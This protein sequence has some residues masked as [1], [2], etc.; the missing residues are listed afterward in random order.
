MGEETGEGRQ[1]MEDRRWET[2]DGTGDGRQETREEGQKM[3]DGRW[4]KMR[5]CFI[6]K[7]MCF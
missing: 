2:R 7:I 6:R 3:V 5:R 4:E 1:E